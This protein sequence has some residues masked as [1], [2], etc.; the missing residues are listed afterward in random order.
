MVKSQ[1]SF[2]II[3]CAAFTAAGTAGP[4]GAK[5]LR[6]GSRRALIGHVVP[7]LDCLCGQKIVDHG[8]VVAVHHDTEQF[9]GL[10][11]HQVARR[12]RELAGEMFDE[13]V[14]HAHILRRPGVK[15]DYGALCSGSENCLC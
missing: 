9:A 12:R 6:P 7:G 13:P 1:A 14:V 2:T 10:A 5:P 8:A 11:E 15:L 3:Y 4:A